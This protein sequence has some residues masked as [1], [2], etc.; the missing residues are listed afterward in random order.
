MDSAW[1]SFWDKSRDEGRIEGR[2][3]GKMES[4]YSLVSRGVL[5]IA[6]G[7]SELGVSVRKLKSDMKKN[8]YEI[9][10]NK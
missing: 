2:N 3:E 1:Q 4:I 9:P 7:A 6:I 10:T 5:S 8:G